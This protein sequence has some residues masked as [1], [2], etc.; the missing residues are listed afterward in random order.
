MNYSY[1]QQQQPHY[2]PHYGPHGYPILSP[3][4]L[5]TGE[6]KS[7]NS[8][9]IAIISHFLDFIPVLSIAGIV[10]GAIAMSQGIQ[11][12]KILNES[13][14]MYYNALAGIIVGGISMGI[15]I[16]M[17]IYYFILFFAISALF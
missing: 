6:S 16:L 10:M 2:G 15:G 9:T 8:L 12:R 13:H 3:Y 1:G 7:R 5:A 14:Y 17:T 11:A 4:E